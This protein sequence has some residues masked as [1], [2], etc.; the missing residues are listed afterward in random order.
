[1]QIWEKLETDAD[2]SEMEEYVEY[3]SN[4]DELEE[5]LQMPKVQPTK[6]SM[7]KSQ[8]STVQSQRL[9]TSASASPDEM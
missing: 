7:V 6:I 8:A 1:M 9:S 4:E 3:D 5:Q 2:E